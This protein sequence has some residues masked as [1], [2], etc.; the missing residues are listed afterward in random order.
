MHCKIKGGIKAILIKRDGKLWF[1]IVQAGQEPESLPDTGK[2]VG[3]DIG[4]MSFDVDTDGNSI[5]NPR[6]AEKSAVKALRKLAR[7]EKWS[8]N[9]LTIK[10]R[11]EKIYAKANHQRDNFLA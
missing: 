1:V 8:N 3:L 4:L 2:S 9:R 5:E 6:F 11:I 7:L 10:D